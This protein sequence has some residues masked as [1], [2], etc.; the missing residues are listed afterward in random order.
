MAGGPGRVGLLGRVIGP[1]LVEVGRT[2]LDLSVGC[3]VA[4]V[5]M[6]AGR[7]FVLEC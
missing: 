6:K 5:L 4:S 3:M 1:V 2:F 7:S